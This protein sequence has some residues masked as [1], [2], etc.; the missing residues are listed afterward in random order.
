M[1]EYFV[2]VDCIVDC[3]SIQSAKLY[4]IASIDM[5]KSINYHIFT[6]L[7]ESLLL[8]FVLSATTI[9]INDDNRFMHV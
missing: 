3:N 7:N 2:L 5:T 6:T 1:E 9:E 4:Y 8:P